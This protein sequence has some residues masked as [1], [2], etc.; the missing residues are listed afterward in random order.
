MEFVIDENSSLLK[1]DPDYFDLIL[2]KPEDFLAQTT[3]PQCFINNRLCGGLH[4]EESL[5][6]LMDRMR[7]GLPITPPYIDV[8]INYDHNYIP[9]RNGKVRQHEGRHRAIACIEVGIKLM[10]LLIFYFDQVENSNTFS[11]M[12]SYKIKVKDV[13]PRVRGNLNGFRHQWNG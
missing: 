2:V 7:K 8:L 4:K 11:G 12:Q 9:Y 13:P 6:N 10:P 1:E 3:D 5:N